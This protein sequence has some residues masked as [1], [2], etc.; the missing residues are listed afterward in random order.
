MFDR[1]EEIKWAWGDNTGWLTIY[2]EH[3]D[4]EDIRVRINRDVGP[5][6][7]SDCDAEKAA[8]PT[9]DEA[10]ITNLGDMKG[11][12][13]RAQVIAAKRDELI[14]TGRTACTI[15]ERDGKGAIATSV[16]VMD[17][18]GVSGD[19]AGSV[20]VAAFDVYCPEAAS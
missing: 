14:K 9:P 18:Y 1:D 12:P 20:V 7:R 8:A 4:D 17:L 16:N 6:D 15:Q 5:Y 2:V 13:D 10:F 11:W 19:E 3:D